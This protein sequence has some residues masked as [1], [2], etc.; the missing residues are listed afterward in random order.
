MIAYWGT[1][2]P[3]MRQIMSSFGQTE[4]GQRFYL[5]G[6]TA[7]ALQLGHRQSVDLDFF[8]PTEDIPSVREALFAAL[9]GFS[10]VL[11][12]SAWGNLVFTAASVRVG[13]YGYGYTMTSPFLEIE[14]CRLAGI[15]D[16]GL[17]KMDALMS[18]ASRKDFHD[19]YAICQTLPLR[20]LL[21]LAPQKYPHA[22]D[23]EAQV[24]KHLVYFDRADQEEPPILLHSVPWQAVKDFFRQQAI[25]LSKSWLE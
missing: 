9:Q 23:F 5:A 4:I 2:T 7:L 10:P 24:V 25:D 22:R 8:S 13:F 3:I 1:V 21:D 6:G 15:A 16:I 20:R 18:R 19:L 11:T 14:N 12:G 17:M